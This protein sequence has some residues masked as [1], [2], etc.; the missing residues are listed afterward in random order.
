MAQVLSAAET[1]RA[2]EFV[3]RVPDGRSVSTLV[4]ATPI[5]T[6]EGV[7]A[8]VVVT[9]QDLTSLGEPGRWRAEFL[10]MVNR[11]LRSPLTTPSRA[12]STPCWSRSTTWTRP[13]RSSSSASSGTSPT[14]CAIWWAT[15]WTWPA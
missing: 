5:R 3:L 9:L 4:N 11:E 12:P 8:S 13:R 10:E 6:E 14:T 2:E 7:V 1:V 15:C